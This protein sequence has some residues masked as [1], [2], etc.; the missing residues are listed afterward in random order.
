MQT[1][2]KQLGFFSGDVDG[3][4]GDRTKSAVE[5]FQKALGIKQ[6]GEA[7][8]TLQEHLYSDAAPNSDITFFKERQKFE[9]L[10]PGDSS[11]AVGNLQKQLWELGYL[12]K[13]D[14]EDQVNDFNEATR[15][16]V[17]EAQTAMGYIHADGVAGPEFQAFL[18]SKYCTIIKKN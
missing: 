5:K 6:T 15:Q 11:K 10:Q 7:S 16:A 13:D 4:Y 17:S 8:V 3:E 2:L 18:F 9:L 1:R 14:V 12:N